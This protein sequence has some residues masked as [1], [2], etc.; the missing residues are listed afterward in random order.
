MR[1]AVLA[2]GNSPREPNLDSPQPS[3]E[4]NH[5]RPPWDSHVA[6]P[7]SSPRK[8]LSKPSPLGAGEAELGPSED[9]RAAG[10]HKKPEQRQQPME[11]PSS[12]SGTSAPSSQLSG[13][14]RSERLRGSSQEQPG[15]RDTAGAQTEETGKGQEP[16]GAIP[17]RAAPSGANSRRWK[18]KL[19]KPTW[20]ARLGFPPTHITVRL[21]T[22]FS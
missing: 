3:K 8:I 13:F 18:Q 5:G 16:A 22:R 20:P 4:K 15:F 21:D 19:R 11:E 6:T 10:G 7:A 2:W 9:Q 17:A 1:T 14:V 12:A